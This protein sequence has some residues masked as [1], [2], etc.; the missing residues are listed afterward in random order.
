MPVDRDAPAL[1]IDK[2]ESPTRDPSYYSLTVWGRNGDGE[3]VQVTLH[4]VDGR[5]EELEL[6]AGRQGPARLPPSSALRCSTDG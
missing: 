3:D 1:A 2:S 4:V 5:L 6:W